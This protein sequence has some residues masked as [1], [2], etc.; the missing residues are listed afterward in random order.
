MESRIKISNGVIS[1]SGFEKITE[2]P[3]IRFS[4]PGEES[5]YVS[6]CNN[7]SEK[8]DL[9]YA[10]TYEN[11]ENSL[12]I[13]DERLAKMLKERDAERKIFDYYNDAY[14]SM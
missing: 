12:I 14:F 5:F 13:K 1:L 8:T 2:F 6:G 7:A 10:T 3:F 4:F 11:I 9:H